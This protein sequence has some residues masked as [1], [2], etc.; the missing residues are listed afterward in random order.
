MQNM[1]FIC[2]ITNVAGR[3]H[4]GCSDVN[5]KT[6]VNMIKLLC[7]PKY[8][9]LFVCVDALCHSHDRMF[10]CLIGLDKQNF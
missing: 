5:R 6:D 10:P 4:F 3:A 1:H 7:I 8:K 2:S 9:C